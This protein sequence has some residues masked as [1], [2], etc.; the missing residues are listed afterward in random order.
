MTPS[1]LA[2]AFA[3]SGT[4]IIFTLRALCKVALRRLP[5]R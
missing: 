4:L 3:L 1:T 2:L 5:A